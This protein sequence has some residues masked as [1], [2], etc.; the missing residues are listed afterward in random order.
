M[1][2]YLDV[3]RFDF[4]IIQDEKY[5]FKPTQ[6][7]AFE[8]VIILSSPEMI[9]KDNLEYCKHA[10]LMLKAHSFIKRNSNYQGNL[11]HAICLYSRKVRHSP[12]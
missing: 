4:I 2:Q 11:F 1:Y 7:E 12:Y 3:D 8:I 6:K 5:R 10:K 9:F